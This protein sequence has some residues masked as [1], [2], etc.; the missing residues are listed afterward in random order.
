M[1]RLPPISTLFPYTTLF[2]SPLEAA[3]RAAIRREGP[4]TVAAFMERSEEYTSELQSRFE[5]V[6][7]LP[8][9][10][11]TVALQPSCPRLAVDPHPHPTS[12]SLSRRPCWSLPSLQSIFR[13]QAS[14]NL[15]SPVRHCRHSWVT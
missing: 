9:E 13:T 10:K 6:C 12:S 15:C 11:K 4:L 8:L 1:I 14:P 3:L 2:R 7:R 5:I